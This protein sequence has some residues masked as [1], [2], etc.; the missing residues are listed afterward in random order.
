MIKADLRRRF[1]NGQ[2]PTAATYLDQFPELQAFDT[3]VLSLVYE[4]YCLNEE[5]GTAP[6]AESFCDRYPNW[7]SSL[8]SQLEYHNLFSEAAGRRRELP[9][10]PEP[11]KISK[12]FAFNRCWE[13]AECRECSWHATSRWEANRSS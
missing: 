12:N 1:E 10:F 11:A 13:R 5:C 7:K 2:K 6:N 4:E 8:I 9:A 3:R